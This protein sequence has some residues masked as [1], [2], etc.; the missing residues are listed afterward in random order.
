MVLL[1]C[2]ETDRTNFSVKFELLYNI[3]KMK[4]DKNVIHLGNIPVCQFEKYNN[5]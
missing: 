2:C 1:N 3:F 5:T 4:Q